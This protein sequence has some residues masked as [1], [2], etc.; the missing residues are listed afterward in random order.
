ME[1]LLI[2]ISVIWSA[3]EWCVSILF[4]KFF[5]TMILLIWG[6]SL[7]KLWK[8]VIDRYPSNKDKESKTHK[9][10][11]EDN[12]EAI[13]WLMYVSILSALIVIMIMLAG[14]QYDLY[15][16]KVLVRE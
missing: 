11:K 5:Y 15:D 1:E 9:Q 8:E 4:G 14:L 2:F 3:L 10:D 12:K 13:K 7:F 6:Y 16:Q